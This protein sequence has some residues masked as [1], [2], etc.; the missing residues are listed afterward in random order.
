MTYYLESDHQITPSPPLLKG[1]EE[2]LGNFHVS[3]LPAV[4]R[5]ACRQT[6]VANWL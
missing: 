2:G 5:P 6:G 1:G 4:G 3:C